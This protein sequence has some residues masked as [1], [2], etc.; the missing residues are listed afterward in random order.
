M[1]LNLAQ[2]TGE[3][4]GLAA[5]LWAWGVEFLPRLVA[6]ALIL[7]AGF[8]L[9]G[10]L[11]RLVGGVARRTPH[12]DLTIVPILSTVV[13]Y[14]ILLFVLIIALGQIGVQTTS[15]LAVLGA[16]GLAIGLALQGTLQNIAAG[17]MLLYLR[18]FR[19]GDTIET[20]AITGKVEQIG[21]F[22]SQLQTLDG[23]FYFVPNSALWNVPL[24]NHTRNPRRQINVQLRVAYD[25]DLEE[26]RRRLTEMAAADKRIAADPAP[27]V[28]VDSYT[29][30]FV[31]VTLR[32]WAAT[33]VFVEAQRAMAEEAKRRLQAAGI[34]ISA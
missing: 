25:A 20:P 9:A 24:K 34:R 5:A 2:A 21:L 11:A 13:R 16:A 14:A 30:A 15:L 8:W 1:D 19:I 29:D 17:I 3:L 31:I 12:I 26:V 32:A 27:Q 33:P 28:F 23:L 10:W 22:A 7:L 6:A 18:P 4:S